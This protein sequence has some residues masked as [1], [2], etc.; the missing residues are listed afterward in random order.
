MMTRISEDEFVELAGT[1]GTQCLGRN[2]GGSAWQVPEG[3]IVAELHD[4]N[5]WYHVIVLEKN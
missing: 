2:E 1:P 3:P 4:G 5:D